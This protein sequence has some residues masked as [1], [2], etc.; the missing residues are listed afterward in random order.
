VGVIG[1]GAGLSMMTIDVIKQAGGQPA[2]FL[3]IG[4]G[5]RAERVRNAMQTVL[6][7][8]QVEGIVINILVE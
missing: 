1:N 7:D 6:M 4:G 2:N 3:D 8:P 5:A